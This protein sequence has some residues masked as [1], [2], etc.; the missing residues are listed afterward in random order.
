MAGGL[1]KKL[2]IAAAG[3]AALF[4]LIST[5]VLFHPDAWATEMVKYFTSH[6]ISPQAII[7]AHKPDH[8]GPQAI[9]SA[10]KP[11]YRPTSHHIGPQAIISVHKPSY[12]STSHHIG[13]QAIISAHKPNDNDISHDIIFQAVEHRMSI[14]QNY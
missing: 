11:S 5:C 12:R 8:I 7:S 14:L 4:S 2:G 9:I 13:S 6:H 1:I 10:H 3:W